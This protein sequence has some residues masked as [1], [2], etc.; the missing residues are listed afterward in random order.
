MKNTTILYAILLLAAARLF[1]SCQKEINFPPPVNVATGPVSAWSFTHNGAKYEGCINSAYYEMTNG[2]KVLSIKGND[3][4][5]NSISILIPVPDGKL[6]SGSTYTAAQGAALSVDDKN[7]NTHI[8]NS[9][10][11]SF[12]FT[13]TAITDTSIVGSFTASLS[14]TS[15]ATYVITNGNIKAFIGK[16][17]ICRQNTGGGSGSGSNS[18]GTASYSLIASG[19]NCSDVQIRGN[20]NTGTALTDT[21]TVTIKVNVSKIGTWSMTTGTVDGMK[22]SGSGTF[23]TTG[24]QTIVLVGAGTPKDVGSIAFPIVTANSNCTF[25]I[26]VITSGAAPCSPA[27]NTADFSGVSSDSYSSVFHDA[28]SSFGGY[29]ITA[30]GSKTGISLQFPGPKAPTP[31][32]YHVKPVG[33]ARAIDDVAVYAV[34]SNVLWQ[35]SQGNVYVTVKNGKVNAVICAVSFTGSL[36]GPSFTTKLTAS[37][38]EN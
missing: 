31:G 17:N 19:A 34:A 12:S 35:S 24:N 15:N 11:S 26:P 7:G 23:T 25:Y 27:N 8:S 37:I 38:T 36:G 2:I 9:T 33:G 22:F 4:P 6:T 13:V 21:S 20:Y 16:D 30:N 10:P 14:D 5:G 29:T 1:P 18:G 3:V 32:I 28:N